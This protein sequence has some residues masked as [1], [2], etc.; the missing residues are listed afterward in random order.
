MKKIILLIPFILCCYLG[1]AQ[2]F[3][4]SIIAGVNT[5]QV[6]GDEVAGFYKFGFN[7]GASVMLPLD[8]KMRW[9][10]TVE[11]LYT[12]K[13]SYQTAYRANAILTPE[14]ST[15]YYDNADRSVPFNDKIKY[16][17]DLD[18]VEVPILFHYE[19]F[20]TGWAFGAGV[21]WSRLVN[22]KEI[23]N[24][25]T[26]TTSLRSGTYRRDDWN[27]IADLKIKIW[28]GLKFN[29]RYQ[30]S[31]C[32]LRT[33]EYEMPATGDTW[34]RKEYNN[35][36]S[37]RLIYAFNEKYV[38]NSEY[39]KGGGKGPRWIRDTSKSWYKN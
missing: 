39:I 31:L 10:A 33:R 5:T 17:L 26:T 11:L 12:Q 16:K 36:I 8:P 38:K 14:T 3:I 6:D 27:I 9:F 21:S 25:W 29:I 24:G 28:K 23:E 19:D 35:A 22:V 1:S 4:G 2:R 34:Q 37:F 20:R 13:G 7:G 32:P 18:Y 30:Y 15:L